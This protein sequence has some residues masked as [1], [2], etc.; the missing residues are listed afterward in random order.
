MLAAYA[1]FSRCYSCYKLPFDILDKTEGYIW[2]LCEILRN[3]VRKV[4]ARIQNSSIVFHEQSSQVMNMSTKLTYKEL[5]QR[6][7]ELE[8]SESERKKT[9]ELLWQQ[10]EIFSLLVNYSSD[11]LVL[12]DKNGE[13]KFISPSAEKITG[14]TVGELQRP[15][16]EIIHPE[17]LHQVE[18]GFEELLNNPEAVVTVNYRHKHKD[19]G[20]RYFETVGRNFLD[21]PL[22]QGIVA[23]VRD[24]SDRK[25]VEEALYESEAKYKSLANN[26]NVG[27][28]R[29][30]VD[31]KGK[32]IQA[33]PAIVKMFGYDS[34]E[35]FL[36]IGVSDLYKDPLEREDFIFKIAK[37]GS[38]KNELLELQKKGSSD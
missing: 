27:V 26:L 18:R 17:D 8:Q 5:E 19:G 37:A 14:Y 4:H 33:N 15:F 25:Q 21:N 6:V 12:I 24:I 30:S 3:V 2:Q 28:Y 34:R 13:Q 29:N 20:Y 1:P 35:E 31:S 7:Q 9:G 22:V 38:I 23:N 10:K 16:A 36:K 11:I 32:F